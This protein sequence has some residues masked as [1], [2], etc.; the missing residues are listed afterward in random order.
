MP[1]VQGAN[2]LKMIFELFYSQK[3]LQCEQSA[4]EN[5]TIL[6]IMKLQF[7]KRKKNIKKFQELPNYIIIS[8]RK[9]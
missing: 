5:L 9:S 6:I 4:S 3:Q 8:K 1:K 7:K 2:N